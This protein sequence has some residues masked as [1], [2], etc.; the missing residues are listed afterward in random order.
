VSDLARSEGINPDVLRWARETA[1]LSFEEA[2]ERLGL[3]DTARATAVDQP[4]Q[5]EAGDQMPS[6]TTLEKAVAAYRRPLIVYCMAAPPKRGERTAD[7]R[8][9]P[10]AVSKR[11]NAILDTLIRDMKERQQIKRDVVGAMWWDQRRAR[12]GYSPCRH[13]TAVSGSASRR[14]CPNWLKPSP[15]M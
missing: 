8:S 7:F 12:P 9:Q 13:S 1:G 6:R 14:R 3:K 11:D 4:E 10:G 15:S 2:A 5:F